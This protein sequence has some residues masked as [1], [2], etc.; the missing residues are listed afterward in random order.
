MSSAYGVTDMG[1]TNYVANHGSGV[2]GGGYGSPDHRRRH[3]PGR[4]RGQ[5]H[6]HHR[7]HA[8]TPWPCPR[9]SS[10]TGPRC[11]PTQPGDE[12]VAYKY[13]GFTGTLPSDT[14]CAGT[15][16][17]WNGYN[18]RGFM[19]ASGEARCVSY[20]HYY[21]PNS[22]NFDCI[23]NDPTMTYIAVGYRAARSRHS[24]GVNVLL[25]DGSVRF[26]RDSI[27]PQT[28]RALGTRDRRRGPGRGLLTVSPLETHTRAR[29]A[30]V[31]PLDR[32]RGR[33]SPP[34]RWSPRS[35]AAPTAWGSSPNRCSPTSASAA[36]RSP[37]LNFW[38]TLVGAAFC[39]P[40]G[41]VIDRFGVRLVLAA[42]LL[43]L[44]A[45]V[46]GHGRRRAGGRTV[47]TARPRRCSSPAGSS[48]RPSRSTCSCSS[49]SR[50]G[51]GRAP[52]RWSASRSSGRSPGR[53]PGAVIGVY[54]FLVALGFMA[55]FAGVKAA[56]EALHAD[57]RTLWAGIGWV[58]VGFGVLALLVV[59]EPTAESPAAAGVELNAERTAA[60]RSGQALAHARLLGVRAGDLVLRAGR[61]RHVAVQP[62][63]AGRARVRPRRAS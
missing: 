63:A 17:L 47:G 7:R 22:K 19:W 55:A 59:R 8:R 49:C 31:R 62:V 1:P 48:G 2:S 6:R 56:F 10:A 35:R 34:P 30:I 23:A 37:P 24:G 51:S 38:A 4:D 57:W 26:V 9:A 60:T 3:L 11:P 28:W 41:W 27:D 54:S 21:T 44:G 20:N 29:R 5:D 32:R 61:G 52:C 50:A 45:T 42:V 14:N 58:L 15:P 43:A 12:K 36:S 40:V 25:G 39:L 16:S 13:L 18:R 46:V 53:R 33:A